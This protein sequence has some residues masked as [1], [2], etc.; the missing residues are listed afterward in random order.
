MH[1]QNNSPV[2]EQATKCQNIDSLGMERDKK[3]LYKAN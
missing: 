2:I 1:S 3:T